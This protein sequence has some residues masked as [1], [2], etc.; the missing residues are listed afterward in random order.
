MVTSNQEEGTMRAEAQIA[1]PRANVVKSP[2]PATTIGRAI[3]AQNSTHHGLADA[4]LVIIEGEFTAAG[5]LYS[6]PATANF[7]R[8]PTSTSNSSPKSP[9]PA[10]A[11]ATAG[12]W[13]L[14]SSIWKSQSNAKTRNSRPRTTSSQHASAAQDF[15]HNLRLMDRY[16]TRMR[17]SYERAIENL[18][19][20]R[21]RRK[22]RKFP[23]EP[24][25]SGE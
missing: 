15:G 10:A 23:N 3:C 12:R 8:K 6:K 25:N 11:F 16:E 7:N 4:K 22:N 19:Q 9:P 1:A 21:D 24:K 18:Y 13:K 20:F 5:K 17:R 14:P 2:R